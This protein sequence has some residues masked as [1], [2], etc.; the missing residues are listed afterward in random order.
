V[1]SS[2]SPTSRESQAA[3]V[4]ALISTDPEMKRLA[5]EFVMAGLNEMLQQLKRGDASTRA[6]IAKSMSGVVAN[7]FTQQQGDDGLTDL[8]EE[9]HQ[10]M[11]EMRGEMGAHEDREADEVPTEDELVER[12]RVMVPKS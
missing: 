7:L 9:M 6:T 2:T 8:R 1:P 3:I 4:T 10:M 12:H 11:S 5:R